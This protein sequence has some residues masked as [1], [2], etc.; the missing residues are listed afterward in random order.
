MCSSKKADTQH[1]SRGHSS[2]GHRSKSPGTAQLAFLRSPGFVL[3]PICAVSRRKRWL[4]TF[5]NSRANDRKPWHLASIRLRALIVGVVGGA[6]RKTPWHIFSFGKG[7]I[8][9]IGR[10]QC[11]GSKRIR[12]QLLPGSAVKDHHRTGQVVR[13]VGK[14]SAI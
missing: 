14:R 4:K 6:N 8:Q 7:H 9:Q 1:S 12:T 11:G 5:P 2:R 3:A 13:F 10:R